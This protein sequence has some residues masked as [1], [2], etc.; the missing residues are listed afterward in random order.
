VVEGE[1]VV[2]VGVGGLLEE[3]FDICPIMKLYLSSIELGYASL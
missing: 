2:D 3:V 1:I